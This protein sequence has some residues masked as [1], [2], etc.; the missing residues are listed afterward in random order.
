MRKLLK[1]SMTQVQAVL[2]AASLAAVF[3]ATAH[4][5]DNSSGDTHTCVQRKSGEVRIVQPDRRCGQNE[6]AKERNSM[7]RQGPTGQAGPQG[8]QGDPEAG[9]HFAGATFAGAHFVVDS[10]G[11][12]VGALLDCCS[13]IAR[14]AMGDLVILPLT[15]AG[16]VQSGWNLVF[17]YESS[18]CSGPRLL[19]QR[20]LFS[21]TMIDGTTAYYA[22]T[23]RTVTVHSQ[24]FFGNCY[25][26]NW[27]FAA[28]E[29]HQTDLSVFTPP[30]SVK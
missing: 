14:D 9:A 15:T 7:D 24:I 29:V 28:G 16:F 11:H 19:S 27:T 4:A 30:F 10:A 3:P 6:M 17:F 20:G 8:G 21:Q 13:V 2:V 18:D 22:T 25:A 12:T 23:S 26:T 1:A 5:V